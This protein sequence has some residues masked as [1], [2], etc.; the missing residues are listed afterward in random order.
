MVIDEGKKIR[1]E[2]FTDEQPFK[3]VR[4]QLENAVYRSNIK[5]NKCG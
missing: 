2:I 3:K 4:A 5:I 1:F